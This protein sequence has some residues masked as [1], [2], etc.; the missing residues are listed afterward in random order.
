[1]VFLK[2]GVLQGSTLDPLLFLIYINN[3]ADN[4]I[5]LWRLFVDDT[6]ISESCYDIN[7]LLKL[8]KIDLKNKSVLSKMWLVNLNQTKL[9]L[10]TL[11][12]KWHPTVLF[13]VD[14]KGIAPVEYHKHLGV[15]LSTDCK[16]SVHI[17]Y[18]IE[19]KIHPD[20]IQRG[21][22]MNYL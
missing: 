20:K 3:I 18:I 13:A 9:K 4:M 14:D 12:F 10:S 11:I 6:S 21:V 16:W 22:T 15:V 8:V 19:E 1:M 5:G 7:T 17:N 2:V